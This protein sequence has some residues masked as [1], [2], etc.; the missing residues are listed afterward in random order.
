MCEQVNKLNWNY[1]G[2]YG[3]EDE[4]MKQV[5]ILMHASSST[6]FYNFTIHYNIAI[7]IRAPLSCKDDN[8]TP[9]RRKNKKG[10]RL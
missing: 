6:A 9:S 8:T 1:I 7:H 4:K 5:A 10:R 3:R 2:K